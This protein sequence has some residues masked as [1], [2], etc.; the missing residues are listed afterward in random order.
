MAKRSGQ[1]SSGG[2]DDAPKDEGDLKIPRAVRLS[3][4]LQAQLERSAEAVMAPV[5]S[6]NS[7][8]ACQRQVTSPNSEGVLVA[9]EPQRYRLAD[10]GT[11]RFVGP[12]PDV[13]PPAA[14]NGAVA[15][16]FALGR[17]TFTFRNQVLA[18]VGSAGQQIQ[19]S[20]IQLRAQIEQIVEAL[21]LAEA[22]EHRSATPRRVQE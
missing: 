13:V 8:A 20:E 15:E 12:M 17:L 9:V 5:D 1:G 19:R 10:G 3:P 22:S 14:Q 18:N 2:Q 4:S 7:E 16:G 6:G 21:P 11:P